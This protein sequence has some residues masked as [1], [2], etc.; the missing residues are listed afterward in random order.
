MGK[1]RGKD[2]EIGI[3]TKSDMTL[4][5]KDPRKQAWP[6]A[7]VQDNGGRRGSTERGE[8]SQGSPPGCFGLNFEEVGKVGQIILENLAKVR[9]HGLRSQEKP[10]QGFV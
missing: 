8:F 7:H 3:D 10:S 1:G 4:A 9:S 5:R 2:G 6:T